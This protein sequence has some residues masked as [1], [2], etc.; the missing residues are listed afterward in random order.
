MRPNRLKPHLF[1]IPEDD[2]DRSIALG[3][4]GALN[5][6]AKVM[7]NTRGWRKVEKLLNKEYIPRLRNNANTHLVIVIDFD[8]WGEQRYEKVISWVPNE[9]KDRVFIL[10]PAKEP[11]DLKREL[12]LRMSFEEIG[13]TLVTDCD[14]EHISPLWDREMLSHTKPEFRR[15]LDTIG[16]KL[17]NS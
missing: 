10:G 13:G 2:K 8:N 4:L 1:I 14:E 5:I 12:K 15:L 6:N 17:L 9:L 16:L 7:G 3:A 11:K